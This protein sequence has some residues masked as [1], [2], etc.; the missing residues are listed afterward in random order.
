MKKTG[1]KPKLSADAQKLSD[2]IEKYA[3]N[4]GFRP[5]RF[6][7]ITDAFPKISKGRIKNVFD[8]LYKNNLFTEITD[9]TYL[10]EHILEQAKKRLLEHLKTMQ[11]IRA[12]QYKEV[13]G[14]SRN[15][16]RDILDY[17]FDHGVTVREKGTH[18]LAE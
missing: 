9:G 14:V 5:F 11:T 6:I 4:L 2:A 12:V 18:R 1:V 7:D 10:H 17:F 13:L 3:I 16:A 8:Y 15:A